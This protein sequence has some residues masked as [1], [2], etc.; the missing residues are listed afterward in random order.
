MTVNICQ[1][2][3]GLKK[4]ICPWCDIQLEYAKSDIHMDMK[5]DEFGGHIYPQFI[6]CPVKRHKIYLILPS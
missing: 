3:K 6:Y 5:E 2:R 1:P 4:I